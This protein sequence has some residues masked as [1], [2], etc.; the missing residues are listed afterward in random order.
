MGM[1]KCNTVTKDLSDTFIL[2]IFLRKCNPEQK[3]FGALAV[4]VNTVLRERVEQNKEY[5]GYFGGVH[6]LRLQ[7]LNF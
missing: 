1:I 3:L 2:I 7:D 4:R 5:D 6:K